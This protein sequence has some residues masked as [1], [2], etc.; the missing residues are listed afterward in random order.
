ML[1]CS[2]ITIILFKYWYFYISFVKVKLSSI[3]FTNKCFGAT[4]RPCLHTVSQSLHNYSCYLKS[5]NSTLNL[6]FN[7][8]VQF[9]L[10]IKITSFPFLKLLLLLICSNI[11][12][13]WN[14][15]LFRVNTAPLFR[16]LRNCVTLLVLVLIP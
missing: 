16:T 5:I 11:N 15:L 1:P 2:K 9:V 7:L 12:M 10:Y 3:L 8:P 13:E 14:S 6:K 4:Q